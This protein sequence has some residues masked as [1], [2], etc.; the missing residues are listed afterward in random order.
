[1]SPAGGALWNDEPD[2]I[3]D[4]AGR[5][6]R[7]TRVFD[8]VVVGVGGDEGGRDALELAGHL[9][10]PQGRITRVHVEVAPRVE[11][12]AVAEVQRVNARSVRQGLH[13]F[14]S[15]R[16]ADLLVIREGSHDLLAETLPGGETHH[17]LDDPP[18]A[19]AVA[20]RGYAAHPGAMSKIGVGYDGSAE[21]DRALAVARRI[22]ME[23]SAVL[24]AVAA[25]PRPVYVG[26]YGDMDRD[27]EAEIED[28]RRRVASLG[29]LEPHAEFADDPVK[30]LKRYGD[31]VDL[32]VLGTRHHRLLHRGTSTRIA[33][34]LACPL[35]V[36]P[37]E[38]RERSTGIERIAVG[39]D[40]RAEGC[41]AAWLAAMI[42]GITGA[43]VTLVAV[44]TVPIAR[45]RSRAATA[46][47][48]SAALREVRDL[49][50]P[51][52]STRVETDWSV[53]R[54]LQRA[55][56]R[57][58]R[59]L[60]VL[61]SS[62]HAAEGRAR[63]GRHARQILGDAPCAVAVAPKGLCARGQRQLA[64]IGVGY[65]GAPQSREA[66]RVGGTLARAAGARLIVRA[67]VD[68]R[69]PYPGPRLV[70]PVGRA[71]LQGV[72]DE[73]IKPEVES[74]RKDAERAASATGA[75]F[76][77]EAC[78]GSP[79]DE[80]I[81]LSELVDLLLIGPGRWG[82]AARVVLGATGE[83]LLRNAGCSVMIV[84]GPRRSSVAETRPEASGA[85]P[86]VA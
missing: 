78:S 33:D 72:W 2:R 52:A 19:V 30:A 47:R 3:A 54:A 60:L 44:E 70:M 42:A 53:P 71:E 28:A 21:S 66:V 18:C 27:A 31:S 4:P 75:D 57:G 25:V 39:I 86:K 49:V 64:T 11:A 82:A 55:V 67:I 22:A 7:E 45:G 85:R 16:D 65:D 80:L 29:E 26:D 50:V 58:R 23:R 81:A 6:S 76:S 24:S 38:G 37:P 13:A 62:R 51:A 43:A 56:T 48:A 36:I 10:S 9:A 17:V 34:G 63:I 84:P 35:L 69:L 15:S 61:G 73:A 68:D 83:E 5:R 59:D 46:G 32:L 79:I 77:V 12:Q 40:G 1:M 41:D 74:L 14:A 8:N 20:P